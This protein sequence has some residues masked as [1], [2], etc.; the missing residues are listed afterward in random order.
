MVA[1]SPDSI[2]R[3]SSAVPVYETKPGSIIVPGLSGMRKS[4]LS[5]FTNVSLD[6]HAH[7]LEYGWKMQLVLDGADSIEGPS[8]PLYNM[9][10]RSPNVQRL[11]QE[12]RRTFAAIL[13]LPTIQRHS[14]RVW[15]GTKTDGHQNDFQ[16]L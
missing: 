11:S 3:T 9:P 13:R 7:I 1:S 15:D 8:V 6:A 14:F 2:D 5:S 12:S 10:R 4:S 16:R